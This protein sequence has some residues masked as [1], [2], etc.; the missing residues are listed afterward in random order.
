M[1]GILQDFR[2]AIRILK[3]SPGFALIAALTIALGIAATTTIFSIVNAVL[4]RPPPGIED[5]GQLVRI[6]RIAEDGSSYNDLSYPNYRDYRDGENGLSDL[7][8]AAL[9]PIVVSG[10]QEPEWMIGLCV[11]Q[12]FFSVMG[13][14][15]ALGRFFLPEEDRGPGTHLVAVLS[16]GTWARRFG[17]D[18]SIVGQTVTLNRRS[19]TVVGVTQEGFRGPNAMAA[20]GIW[21]PISAAPT[22]VPDIEMES[23]A[24][25]WVDA[26]GR[27]APGVSVEQVSA[28]LNRISANLRAEYPEGN[29]DY[30]VDVQRYAPISRR[31]FGPA[32]AF[33]AFLFVISGT[34]LLIACLNVGS[35]LLA[36]A[37]QRG[38]EMA[39]RLALGAKRTR[40][41]R[42][43]LTESVVLFVIGGAGGVLITAYMTQLLATYQL[44]VDVP[45]VLDFSPDLRVLAFSL[46]VGLLTG[47][48]FGL[49]P[50]LHV[51][52]PD[53]H[54]SLKGGQGSGPRSRSR[55]RNSFVV[56]QV[57][58]SALLLIGAGL[59]ARGLARA[60]SIDIGF[61]PEGVHALSVELDA[62]SYADLDAGQFYGE[63]LERASQLPGVESAGL[64]DRPPVTLGGQSTT[65]AVAGGETIEEEDRPSTDFARVSPGYLEAFRI[66]MLRGRSFS[67][68]DRDG[69][70]LVAVVNETFA[71]RAWPG[72]SPIG[73]RVQLGSLDDAEIEVVGV[74]R[75]AKYRTLTESPRA[76]VYVPFQQWPAGSMVLVARVGRAGA[77]VAGPLRE[78]VR[79][80]DATMPVDANV[81]YVDLMSIALL[82]SR[83]AAFFATLFGALGLVLAA[84]GLYGVLAFAVAQRTREIGIRMALGAEPG[85]VRGLVLRDGVK[86]AGIGLAIGVAIALALTHL[87][88]G[89]LYGLSPTDPITFGGIVLLLLGVALAASY[90]PALRATRT[91]PVEA[92]RT[93]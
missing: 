29:P 25:D 81:A 63:L 46:A 60:H 9:V 66:P 34:V 77:G 73:R 44:P 58:G 16:H 76:M 41:V 13:V 87:L 2:Y 27:R 26:F 37:S 61:E 65:Y 67:E 38:K 83:A 7:A 74:V 51:T 10:A 93:E 21:L 43:L 23:R 64:T 4:L 8:A 31:A 30:G 62:F 91:D 24:A 78:I 17:G 90:V 89:L 5:A 19:F 71:M 70:A 3:R 32:M 84:M 11:S 55:L 92:L 53:L 14:R 88:R 56:A 45:L 15:P 54:T 50:A 59:F 6:Y 20:V 85:T 52:K 35:M 22:I 57:A 80:I 49:A 40:V 47:I 18:S 36:R 42:Q 79:D 12:N 75:N 68:T 82:P 33:S 48:M 86:L 72:E 69:G 28:A 39:M 1:E